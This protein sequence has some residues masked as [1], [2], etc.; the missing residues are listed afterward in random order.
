MVAEV[1]GFQGELAFDASKPDRDT[2]QASD[3]S[4]INALGWRA[5]YSARRSG[6][7]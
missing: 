6:H 7:R 3:V 1:V 4:R 2:T 5:E